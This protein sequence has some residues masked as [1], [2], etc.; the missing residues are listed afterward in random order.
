MDEIDVKLANIQ[1][2]LHFDHIPEYKKEE[3][4]ILRLEV[5]DEKKSSE[6]KEKALTFL[7]ELYSYEDFLAG[8]HQ[9]VFDMLQELRKDMLRLD[10]AFEKAFVK[11]KIAV[12]NHSLHNK[13]EEQHKLASEALQTRYEELQKNS[14]VALARLIGHRWTLP[15]IQSYNTIEKVENPDK[16]LKEVMELEKDN[17]FMMVDQNKS[18]QEVQLYLI[19]QIIDFYL[20]KSLNYTDPDK[21]DLKYIE[22][23]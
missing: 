17:I 7:K 4:T 12:D 19:T 5:V 1:K 22:K 6:Y 21:L 14:E 10:Y 3:L 23:N 15:I 11:A 13:T 18:E 16:Y 2:H 20:K 8:Y 9:L